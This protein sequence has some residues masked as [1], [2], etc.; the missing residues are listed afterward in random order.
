MDD[1]QIDISMPSVSVTEAEAKDLLFTTQYPFA[2][3]D[4]QNS[5]SFP[6]INLVFKTDP[7][8]P[9]PDLG[10]YENT[11]VYKF[12]HGYNYV[13]EVWMMFQ[14]IQG[15]GVQSDP[16][17]TRFSP[18]Q[19]DGGLIAAATPSSGLNNRAYLY[20]DVDSSY[21]Y[22]KVAKN[23]TTAF[24]LQPVNLVG[25]QLLVRV[26]VFVNELGGAPLAP[27]SQV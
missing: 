4:T 20:R 17:D 1:Y 15:S 18:Y 3:L 27:V 2:M 14:R 12:A 5:M 19:M 16:T 24:G 7:P 10:I 11:V 6:S 22:L 13:P 9:P 25:Y 26:Y 23:Y 8:N 21:V